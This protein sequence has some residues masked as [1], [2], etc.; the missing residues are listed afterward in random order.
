MPNND[1]IMTA[2]A[3]L[4]SKCGRY[5][6]AIDHYTR[7]IGIDSHNR[8]S[9]FG[10]AEVLARLRRVGEAEAYCRR[11]IELDTARGEAYGLLGIILG[12]MGRMDEAM[13]A[14]ETAVQSHPGVPSARLNMAR[15][16]VQRGD[17]ERVIVEC[18]KCI[19]VEPH[20]AAYEYLGDLLCRTGKSVE[21]E[22]AYRE[23]V[24]LEPRAAS[25]HYSLGVLL[26]GLERRAEAIQE[27][28]RALELQP[29]DAAAK[30]YLR[31]LTEPDR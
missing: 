15:I 10:M 31:K 3:S 29:E 9:Q 24:K 13:V 16:Y 7:A 17:I 11:A 14:F 20:Y 21:A 22:I 23:A 12:Q 28:R 18:R 26:A 5:Q 6:E 25:V 4:L 30:E 8:E 27:V 19:A 1:R 2:T